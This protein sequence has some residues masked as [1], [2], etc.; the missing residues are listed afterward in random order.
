M[1]TIDKNMVVFD[2]AS[3]VDSF[4]KVF[5]FKN[6]IYR[7]INPESV[8]TCNAI[9]KKVEDWEKCGLV[10]T[11][12]ATFSLKSYPLTVWHEKVE[13]RNY[14][15]E[16]LPEM[17]QDAAIHFLNLNLVLINDGY[18]IKDGHPW[19]IF[20][21][22]GR[23]VFI[24]IGSI[25]P[26][27]RHVFQESMREFRLYFGLPLFMFSKKGYDKTYEF[28][29][30]PIPNHEYRENLSKALHLSS[31]SIPKFLPLKVAIKLLI[32]RKLKTTYKVNK[33]T[34]WAHYNQKKISI[35]R[36][37]EF[38]LKQKAVHDFL[39][40]VP[41]G[42][43]LDV[44]CNK[45]WFSYLAENKGFK[46]VAIDNDIPSLSNLY[47]EVKRRGLN[48]LPLY[49]DFSN[50]TEAHG[51]N[52][53][54]PAFEERFSFDI[55]LVMAMIHHLTY[56]AKMTF[57]DIAGR[58]GKLS[59]KYAVVEFIPR[60]DSYVCKWDQSGMEWYTRDNFIHAF[61]KIFRKYK[62]MKS[63]PDPREIY[64]FTKY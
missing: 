7:A 49:I 54:Y 48:I 47:R 41:Q 40:T 36:P 61:L 2:P 52:D 6:Q 10:K 46:V 50:P 5:Y 12:K 29:K 34:E 32:Q 64:I 45:G 21:H 30:F 33:K 22:R 60:E 18:I 42:T 39:S 1:N 25:V 53:A 23:P 62:A 16:W 13:Y 9:L 31:Y 8:E 15:M 28:L 37:Q 57:D 59:N 17:L 14:C 19:N 56:K 4:G 20:F 38:V 3:I 58:I 63:S 55:V 11:R 35:H 51:L 27:D 26:F 24:D 44:G 43:L